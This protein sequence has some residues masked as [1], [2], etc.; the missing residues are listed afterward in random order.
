MNY[1][2]EGLQ[3]S[4][5]STLAKLISE[6]HPECRHLE[7]GDYSPMELAWCAYLD[8]EEY[9]RVLASYPELDQEIREKSHPENDHII[10]CYTKIKTDNVKFYKDLEGFEIYNDR[11]SF[12]V[13]KDIVLSRYRNWQEDDLIVECSLFQNIIEDMILY[14]DMSDEEIID[15][16]RE[17]RKA[18]GQKAIYIVY[19]KTESDDIRK[20]LETA[21]K[22]RT[23]EEGQEVWFQILCD[24]FNNCPHAMKNDLRDEDGLVSHWKHRQEL[25]LRICKEIFPERYTVLPSK[26]YESVEI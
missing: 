1:F 26:R 6:K 11:V 13:F 20:N 23:D 25:E 15:F 9:Q 7:E 3:G 5:K 18:I 10:V 24:Y 12:E 19:L 21:R 22:D 17:I 4:G 14:R 2:I 8:K 16:Y